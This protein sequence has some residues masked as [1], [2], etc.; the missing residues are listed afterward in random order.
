M[1]CGRPERTAGRGRIA[2]HSL[3]VP[4]FTGTGRAKDCA[5]LDGRRSGKVLRLAR[6]NG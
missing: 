3:S 5:V 2:G 1:T 6:M 4:V